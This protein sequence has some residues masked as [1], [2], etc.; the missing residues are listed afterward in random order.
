MHT[1]TL[2]KGRTIIPFPVPTT[3]NDPPPPAPKLAIAA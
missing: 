2:T 1:I 3:D